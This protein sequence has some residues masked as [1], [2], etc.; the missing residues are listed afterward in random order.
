[1]EALTP[2]TPAPAFSLKDADGKRYALAEALK[3]GP[4][5]LAFF[6]ISCPVCQFTFPFLERLH[7][8]VKGQESLHVWGVSQNDASETR[9]FA[10]EYNCTFPLLIDE[11]GYPVSNQFGLSYVPTL[12]LV[13]P[14]GQIQVSSVGFV[15]ADI[16]AVAGEFSRRLGQPIRVFQA[17]DNVPDFKPG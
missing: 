5:L 11:A 17:A 2:G 7:Q 6:K 9:S 1:M 4:V 14:D 8:E 10:R 13:K 15:R 3:T 12:F 16:E